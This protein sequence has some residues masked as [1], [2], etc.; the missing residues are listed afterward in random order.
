GV[1]ADDAIRGKVVGHDTRRDLALIQLN[2]VPDGVDALPVAKQPPGNGEDLHSIGNPGVSD[3]LWVYT[4]G[5]VRG[6]GKKQW[7]AGGH[8]LLLDLDA[9][10]VEADSPTNPGDSGG[11]RGDDKV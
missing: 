6:V 10:V 2:R 11:P 1:R 4:P 3:N 7:K 8:G 5:H 9:T